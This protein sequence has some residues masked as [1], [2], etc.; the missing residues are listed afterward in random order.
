MEIIDKSGAWFS[1]H[2]EKI[3]QGKEAVRTYLKAHPEIDEE[4]T[5]QIRERLYNKEE[6]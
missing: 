3:G 2:G 5:K 1:Y 6:A 4:I